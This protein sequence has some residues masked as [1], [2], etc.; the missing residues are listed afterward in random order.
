MS[1]EKKSNL[2]KI[3][4][5]A[6]GFGGAAA[7]ETGIVSANPLLVVTGATAVFGSILAPT[8]AARRE[9]WFSDLK[10]ELDN[11]KAKIKDF[12]PERNL[13]NDDVVTAVLQATQ[14]ALRTHNDEKLK[15]LRNAVLNTVLRIN[16]DEDKKSMFL[17]LVDDLTPTDIAVLK[18]CYH[19]H[20]IIKKLVISGTKLNVNETIDKH[21]VTILT[22]FGTYLKIESNFYAVI[23][24]NL[25]AKGLLVNTKSTHTSGLPVNE[26]ENIIKGLISQTNERTTSF[27]REFLRFIQEPITPNPE[28]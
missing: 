22:D 27:G 26:T 8:L 3:K 12:D 15:I 16:I 24:N 2:E 1:E 14:I 17:N 6:T 10:R 13:Q 25:E 28:S 19:P 18:I 11:L 9:K 4:D 23:L 20:E 5:I 7:I 21:Q